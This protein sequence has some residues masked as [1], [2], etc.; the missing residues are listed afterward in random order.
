MLPMA[1]A[2]ADIAGSTLACA[3]AVRKAEQVA[4]WRDRGVTFFS[5]VLAARGDALAASAVEA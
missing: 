3:A 2:Q 1:G 5:L 4:R